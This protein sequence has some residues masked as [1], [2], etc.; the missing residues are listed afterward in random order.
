LSSPP[1]KKR[2]SASGWLRMNIASVSMIAR[3]RVMAATRRSARTDLWD[4]VVGPRDDLV[5][6]HVPDLLQTAVKAEADVVGWRVRPALGAADGVVV[7]ATLDHGVLEREAG[8]VQRVLTG[9]PNFTCVQEVAVSDLRETMA[10]CRSACVVH[11]RDHRHN[12][13]ML[14]PAMFMQPSRAVVEVTRVAR[15]GQSRWQ[16]DAPCIDSF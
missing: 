10:P 9:N 14:T 5:V 15:C 2:H 1:G 11:E 12:S 4:V 16:G 7:E 3:S 6:V 13:W 8:P